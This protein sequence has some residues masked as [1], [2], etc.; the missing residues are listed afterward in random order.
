MRQTSDAVM[1]DGL[2]DS[3]EEMKTFINMLA[4]EPDIARVPLMIDSSDWEVI[5]EGLKCVQGRSIVNS[6]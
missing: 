5:K 2:L 3:R 1:D 4:G 6:I